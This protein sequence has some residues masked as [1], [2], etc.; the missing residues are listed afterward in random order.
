MVVFVIV[1]VLPERG[2]GGGWSIGVDGD[3]LREGQGLLGS[4]DVIQDIKDINW[5]P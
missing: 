4:A 2:G 5:I 3:S 1:M